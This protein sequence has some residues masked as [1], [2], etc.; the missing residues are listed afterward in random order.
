MPPSMEPLG[1][2]P[3]KSQPLARRPQ[4]RCG[5]PMIPSP[6]AS[7]ETKSGARNLDL[8]WSRSSWPSRL[9]NKQTA[10]LVSIGQDANED[11]RPYMEDGYTVFDPLPLH[12]MKRADGWSLFAV[13]D[14]H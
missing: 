7:L 8:A 6:R 5:V 3:V 10:L 4:T 14:G 1:L 13:Y 11:Y 9:D 12:D 2:D